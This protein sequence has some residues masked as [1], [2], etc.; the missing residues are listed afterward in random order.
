M[1]RIAINLSHNRSWYFFRRHRHE[2]DSLDCALGD[3]DIATLADLIA[4]DTPDPAREEEN[5]EF[6]ADVMRC[7]GRLSAQQ[8][9][10]LA[11][12]NLL[13]RSYEEIAETLGVSLGTVKSRIARARKTLRRHLALRYDGLERGAPPNCLWSDPARI[14][15]CQLRLA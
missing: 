11:L 6:S 4:S 15:G 5:R 13:D 1:R 2:T 10:I 7:M 3:A 12:R 9:E 8:R 14:Y